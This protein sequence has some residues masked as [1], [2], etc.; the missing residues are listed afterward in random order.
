MQAKAVTS[1]GILFSF[2]SI[3]QS[4]SRN[5]GFGVISAPI[6]GYVTRF[7]SAS[8]A[9]GLG[10]NS[11]LSDSR[12]ATPASGPATIGS[13]ALPS[14]HMK[15]AGHAKPV[16]DTIY[17][18]TTSDQLCLG[19]TSCFGVPILVVLDHTSQRGKGH[20]IQGAENNQAGLLSKGRPKHDVSRDDCAILLFS[21][22][23]ESEASCYRTTTSFSTSRC[24]PYRNSSRYVPADKL[25]ASRSAT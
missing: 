10:V 16:P 7:V 11:P 15:N 1:N 2:A 22:C 19:V 24:A 12:A 18:C 17:I 25:R 13:G 4:R 23:N 5:H 14:P 21:R 9:A 20:I 8:L 3:N 6:T